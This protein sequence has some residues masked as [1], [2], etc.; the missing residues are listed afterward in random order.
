MP[1][2]FMIP[3]P[4]WPL[5]DRGLTQR[6]I[7]LAMLPFVTGEQP[8]ARQAFFEDLDA[9]EPLVPEG[10]VIDWEL[11]QAG[12]DYQRAVRGEGWRAHLVLVRRRPE[13]QVLVPAE[14]ALL[15]DGIST[16]M[17]AAA[18]VEARSA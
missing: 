11:D 8:F 3:Q 13:V 4:V 16:A 7:D 6:L 14:S 9:I 17:R 2:T 18:P 15:A 10:A 12:G 5:T 1:G